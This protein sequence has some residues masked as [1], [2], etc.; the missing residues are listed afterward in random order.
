MLIV[1]FDPG[2]FGHWRLLQPA[3]GTCIFP[4]GSLKDTDL[5]GNNTREYAVQKRGCYPFV[6]FREKEPDFPSVR[7]IRIPPDIS[8]L[9]E[10]FNATGEGAFIEVIVPDKRLLRDIL[11]LVEKHQGRELPGRV[12]E[13]REPPVEEDEV[14]PARDGYHCAMRSERPDELAVSRPAVSRGSL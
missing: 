7:G 8:G 12:A 11:H 9:F 14:F 1:S 3:T 2:L 13:W 4:E 10:F 5:S 6:L